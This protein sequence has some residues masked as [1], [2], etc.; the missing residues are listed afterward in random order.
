MKSSGARVSVLAFGLAS[1]GDGSPGGTA[2][3]VA[4][5]R[6]ERGWNQPWREE[7]GTSAGRLR[8]ERGRSGRDERGGTGGTSAGGGWDERGRSGRDERGR[9][10]R[11][12]RGRTGW[13][14]PAEGGRARGSGRDERGWRRWTASAEPG[15]GVAERA[16]WAELAVPSCASLRRMA[17]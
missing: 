11:D 14:A 10:G 13:R 15:W 4:E 17:A 5:G 2:A 3:P 9:S 7:G 12:E 8:H 16:A 6:H 1:C